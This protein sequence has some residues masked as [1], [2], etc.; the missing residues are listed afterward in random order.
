MT[1]ISP[2]VALAATAVL[3][4]AGCSAGTADAEP[5]P[6]P[7]AAG[8]EG[9]APV[10]QGSVGDPAG[11]GIS[12]LI[13]AVSDSLMQVQE[14]DS[15]TGVTWTDETVFTRTVTVGLDAIAVGSCVVA[16]APEAEEGVTSVAS[17]V[18]VSDPV[19]GEC[20][21]GFGAFRGPN[22]AAG[23][24][25][26]GF[27]P[28]DGMQ[29]PEG[30]EPPE[31]FELPEGV[32][33]PEAGERP[34]GMIGGG[35]FGQLVA[36]RVAAVSGAALTVESTDADGVATSETIAL[37]GDTE[38]TATVAADPTAIAVGLCAAVRGDTDTRGG[39]TATTVSLSEPGEN[40]CTAMGARMTNRA[41]D[42]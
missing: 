32:E 5:T 3:V 23:E 1:R 21:A 27:E 26:G 39:M 20:T 28:P 6:T 30:V 34:E 37:D 17:T 35:A 24:M 12:G 2:M 11:S 10:R 42:A 13:A 22:P 38:V 25:P 29:L 14:A 40:G 18:L 16:M 8:D 41:G 9:D 31:G 36:G 4:L 33:P 15:Q 19:D 7:T